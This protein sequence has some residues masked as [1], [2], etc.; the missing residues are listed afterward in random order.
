VELDRFKAEIREFVTHFLF[1]QTGRS[2]IVIPVVNLVG[3]QGEPRTPH[4]GRAPATVAPPAD[5]TQTDQDRFQAMRS[6]LLS[7]GPGD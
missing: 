6:R 5:K 4:A 2:P 7:H 1:E 3:S